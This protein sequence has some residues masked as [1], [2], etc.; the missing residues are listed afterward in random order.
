LKFQSFNEDYV[1]RL[2]DGDSDAGERFAAYFGGILYLKLR[3]RLRSFELI[4]DVRQET[5]MRVLLI[6]RQRG[7]NRPE[8]FGALVNG[9]CNNVMRELRRLDERDEPWDDNVEEFIDPTVDLDAELV[10]AE[11]RREIRLVFAALPERDRK[12]LQALYV[13]E[14]PKAEVCRMF[15]VDAAYL[16]VLLHRAKAQF[17][18]LYRGDRGNGHG[19]GAP[20]V[21]PNG[22]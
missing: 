3:V 11:S 10:N 16:R 12:I 1:R 2:T 9:V 22:A 20:P 19:T 21:N 5:L 14:I 15:N 18:K 17:R 4:E 7:V 8:H 13:D 6:L